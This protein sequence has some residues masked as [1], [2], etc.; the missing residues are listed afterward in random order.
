[1]NDKGKIMKDSFGL[2]RHGEITLGSD[3]KWINGSYGKLS[4][5]LFLDD[6][7][8]CRVKDFG[9]IFNTPEGITVWVL[10]HNLRASRLL[11]WYSL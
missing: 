9:G 4:T 2:D 11:S 1:M 10:D 8:F 3:A 7:T 6:K 5:A